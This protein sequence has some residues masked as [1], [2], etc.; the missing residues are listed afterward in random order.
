MDGN[1]DAASRCEKLLC[2]D[3]WHLFGPVSILSCN[4]FR[5]S[6]FFNHQQSRSCPFA[7]PIDTPCFFFAMI[8][9][10]FPEA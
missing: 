9:V 6:D 2:G 4:I 8:V 3:L 7:V 10:E 5:I 1:L